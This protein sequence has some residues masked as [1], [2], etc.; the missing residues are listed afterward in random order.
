M[1]VVFYQLLYGKYP[2][3]G[4]SDYEILKK[5]KNQRPDYAGVN[6]SD[7]AKNFIERCLT[8]NP[9][10]RISW[11]EIYDHPLIK[12]QEKMI[13][14]LTSKLRVN[15]GQKFYSTE[16]KLDEDLMYA[17]KQDF[18]KKANYEPIREVKL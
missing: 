16:I 1:G 6:I 9:K 17:E 13:Y 7:N 4:A 14:G 15:D 2:Y 11:K 10:D 12:Q 3:I 5:I 8:I 18:K